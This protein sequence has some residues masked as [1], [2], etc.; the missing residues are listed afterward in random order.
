MSTTERELVF[1]E[2]FKAGKRIYYF[3]VKQS[4]N[5]EKYISITESKKVN[6]G[7]VENP[8]FIFEK[9]KIFLYKED[10]ERFIGAFE[11]VL[12]V[13]KGNLSVEDAKQL[14]AEA[15][16]EQ[17]ESSAPY[18]EYPSSEPNASADSYGRGEKRSFLDKMKGIF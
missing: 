2:Y 3:D 18:A 4:R 7:S 8:R 11:R 14:Q 12:E 1:S 13:A 10:Y 9:H 6:E 17:A 15:A 16:A 5:G